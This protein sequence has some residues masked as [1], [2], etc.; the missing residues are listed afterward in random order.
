MATGRRLV[1]PSLAEVGDGVG[2]VPPVAETHHHVVPQEDDLQLL[3]EKHVHEVFEEPDEA[4][5][6][7]FAAVSQDLFVDREVWTSLI[8]GID[9]IVSLC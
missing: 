8:L 4:V 2:V 1:Y 6:V 3:A 9:F 7:L 5:D